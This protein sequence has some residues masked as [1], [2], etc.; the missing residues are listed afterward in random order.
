MDRPFAEPRRSRARRARRRSR[1]AAAKTA[2]RRRAGPRSRA[3]AWSHPDGGSPDGRSQPQ[4]TTPTTTPRPVAGSL[5]GRRTSPGR[6]ASCSASSSATATG[7]SG[8]ST[9]AAFM[10]STPRCARAETT[11]SRRIRP[12][13][14]SPNDATTS[15]EDGR[16]R[17]SCTR[18]ITA[19]T[20]SG[21]PTSISSASSGSTARSRLR[22]LLCRRL[23]LLLAFLA[24]RG[25]LLRSGVYCHRRLVHL[26][27]LLACMA[28]LLDEPRELG[29]D[30]RLRLL[31]RELG[32]GGLELRELAA[33]DR[34]GVLRRRRGADAGS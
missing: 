6:A 16:S 23:L 7:S 27:D 25:L 31:R 32:G 9:S 26:V 14:T 15:T 22:A 11:S 20:S 33:E 3:A 17:R 29:V 30:C 28:N 12:V 34:G 4:S 19:T 5:S 1:R 10:L 8:T 21:A 24:L 18:T 13:R 2:S